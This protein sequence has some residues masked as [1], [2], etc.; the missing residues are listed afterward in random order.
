MEAEVAA[1]L[2]SWKDLKLADG[3]GPAGPAWSR[4]RTRDSDRDGTGRSSA[5][6][7][8][9]QDC[10]SGW[11]AD[12]FQLGTTSMSGWTAATSRPV[13][14]HRLVLAGD[15]RLHAR[16]PEGTAR[17]PDR[18]SRKWPELARTA[19]RPEGARAHVAPEL[20][21]ADSALGFWK[22]LDVKFRPLRRSWMT[23]THPSRA[24]RRPA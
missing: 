24:R 11:R 2:A 6:Q 4:A 12:P 15:N 13:G 10:R 17:F 19:D 18:C 3:P 22:V 21:V 20:A 5:G 8:P 9:R 1:F 7:G 23:S 16:R 14:A